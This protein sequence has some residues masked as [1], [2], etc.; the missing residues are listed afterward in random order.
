MIP[1]SF[2][3]DMKKRSIAFQWNG[4]FSL[5]KER[6]KTLV[7]IFGI[8]IPFRTKLKEVR[9]PIRWFYLKE[10]L[11]FISK[12]RLKKLEGTFSFSD[13]MV[14]GILYG[15]ISA[16]G[17]REGDQKVNV[18]INF[19]GENGCRGEMTISLKILFHH[20]RRW[21]FPLLKEMRGRR[22]LRGGE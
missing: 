5:G 10:G 2:I 11:S 9:F 14:N 21:I 19:L 3:W 4:F 12:W 13:P 20:L 17:T 8:P 18:T 15:W 6:E 22:G 7:K 16:F 1:L